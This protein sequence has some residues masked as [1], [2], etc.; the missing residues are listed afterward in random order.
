MYKFRTKLDIFILN[1]ERLN[2]DA[3]EPKCIKSA[4][5][6]TPLTV[7]IKGIFLIT[8]LKN[9]PSSIVGV[10]LTKILPSKKGVPNPTNISL[11]INPLNKLPKARIKSGINIRNDGSCALSR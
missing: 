11:N 4:L 10:Y 1:K 8:T 9:S 2:D 6:P 5:N 7:K 3:K